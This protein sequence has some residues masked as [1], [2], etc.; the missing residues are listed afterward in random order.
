MRAGVRQIFTFEINFR[1]AKLL[2]ESFGEIQRGGS[3]NI[4]FQIMSKLG[5]KGTICARIGIGAFQF[6][7]RRHERFRNIP[8]AELAEATLVIGLS[9]H[10]RAFSNQLT[11]RRSSF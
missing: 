8:S 2:C 7:K 5:M 1:A 3:S 10:K 11:E 9:S 6:K 4:I